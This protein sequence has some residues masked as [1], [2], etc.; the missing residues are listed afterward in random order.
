[1]QGRLC[2]C[3]DN[4]RGRG[5]T[6]PWEISFNFLG[7]LVKS[8]EVSTTFCSLQNSAPFLMRATSLY[9]SLFCPLSP[10]KV[11]FH[12]RKVVY[13]KRSSSP[14]GCLPPKIV[15]HQSLS[16]TYHN[17]LVDLIFVRAVNIPNLSF[18]PAMHDA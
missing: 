16:S 8:G 12:R 2:N 18:L 10:Q 7:L 15:W 14:K 13:R 9:K 17:T 11:V 5:T 1:M 6:H 3:I 4:S